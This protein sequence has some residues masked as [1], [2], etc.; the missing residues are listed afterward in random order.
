[1]PERFGSGGETQVHPIIVV[2]MLLAGA[3]ILILPRKHVM[4]P[5]LA[6]ALLIP[7]D[8]VLVLGPFHFPM[9]RLL[10]AIGWVPM[11]FRKA[12]GKR[13]FS[14]G[15]K[16][17]DKAVILW[18]GLTAI[19]TVALW[20]DT[21]ALNNQMGLLYTVFGLYFLLRSLIRDEDDV[22][23]AVRVLAYVSAVI[24]LIM[25]SEHITDHNP[26]VVLGGSRAWTRETL[27]VREGGLRA[28]GP[29]Q[30]PILA[31]TFGAI[32]LPLY[33]TLW[34]RD[35]ST[36]VPAL[37]GALAATTITFAT[38]SSTPLLAYVGGIFAFC[39]WPLRK[40]MSVSRWGI[41]IVLVGLH[42][43]MKAPVWALIARIDLT[44]GSSSYHRYMLVDQCIRHF[45]D[46]W[47]F[48][49][50]ET[51]SWGWDMWDLANQYVAVAATSGLL[52]LIFFMAI[53]VFGFKYLGRARKA[54]E[55]DR[56]QE[57]FIW[58]FGAGLFA[59]CVAFFGISYFDQTMVLWYLLLAMICAVTTGS[60]R[61]R[62]YSG[63][64]AELEPAESDLEHLPL[65]M[66]L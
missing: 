24:A 21:A 40:Q 46:W 49:V 51:G 36:R 12:P 37:V 39:M 29:F 26:Y 22:R 17:L 28:M 9:L 63:G 48:G 11:F 31:G 15:F 53:L 60:V 3:L 18:A 50:K 57:I 6:G 41:A 54:V 47:L 7:M 45:S 66:S 61:S 58:A 1:M 43:V 23:R 65:Q 25:I 33:I 62:E 14:N 13:I 52:P 4:V 10:I 20:K 32:S 56:R 35:R 30:H 27:M 16:G 44:G 42:F 38:E 64:P 55:G 5:F 19:A 8:Q 59:N 2:A 34:F